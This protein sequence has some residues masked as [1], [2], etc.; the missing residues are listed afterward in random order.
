LFGRKLNTVAPQQEEVRFF[1]I[2]RL[3]DLFSSNYLD[4]YHRLAILREVDTTHA[5]GALRDLQRLLDM[6]KVILRQK[7]HPQ[8]DR[9]GKNIDQVLKKWPTLGIQRYRLLMDVLQEVPSLIFGLLGQLNEYFGKA[10]VAKMRLAPG[11]RPPQA[12]LI[13]ERIMTAFVHPWNP[14][15]ALEQTI[16]LSK[17]LEQFIAIL[18][19][20][21]ALQLA[22]YATGTSPFSRHIRSSFR[23]EGLEGNLERPYVTWDR[24]QLLDRY[25][26][27]LGRIKDTEDNISLLLDCE[28]PSGSTLGRASEAV[29]QQRSKIKLKKMFRFMQDEV[30][31]EAFRR[32]AEQ[33]NKKEGSV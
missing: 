31:W 29:T 22:Q 7:S 28:V 23:T 16:R 5:L 20:S 27:L 15:L 4:I 11:S 17:Q 10:K 1:Y 21:F 8:W 26:D 32:E 33:R 12:L 24:S 2:S 30:D 14:V 18:P 6:A 19:A 9:V 3:L 25:L 13:T